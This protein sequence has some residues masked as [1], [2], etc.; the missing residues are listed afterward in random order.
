MLDY[1]EKLRVKPKHQR[2]RVA[3]FISL[4]VTA[5][6]FTTWSFFTLSNFQTTLAEAE[7]KE[8]EPSTDSLA[9]LKAGF[10]KSFKTL[11]D[12]LSELKGNF[13]KDFFKS[14]LYGNENYSDTESFYTSEEAKGVEMEKKVEEVEGGETGETEKMEI[15]GVEEAEN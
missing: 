8:K 1:I 2:R 9:F 3:F 12:E 13:N 14:F 5:L 15:E 6:I 7:V 10:S 4:S 11:V